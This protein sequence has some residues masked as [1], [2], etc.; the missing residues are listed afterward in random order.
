MSYWNYFPYVTVAE[1]KEKAARSLEKLKKKNQAIE[2]VV[3]SGRT[4]AATWWG[5]AWNENLER[6]A[7]FSNRIG[8]GRSYVRNGAVLDL[9]IHPG[10]VAA[11]V[12]GT[13]AKPY[14][15]SI[16]IHEISGTD[17]NRIK[18]ASEGQLDSLQ[19]LLSGKFPKALGEIFMEPGKGLFPEPREIKFSCSCPDWAS[20]C[21]HV[22]AA[23]YGIGARLD[24]EP[25]LFFTLRKVEMRDLVTEAVEGKSRE[26]LKKASRKS[27]RVLEDVSI[28]EMFGIDLDGDTTPD[29]SDIAPEKPLKIAEPA[30]RAKRVKN[31][32]PKP[33]VPAKRGRPPKSVEKAALGKV[34]TPITSTKPAK[35]KRQAKAPM[36][37]VLEAV[38]KGRKGIGVAQICR[39]TGLEEQKVRNLIY[40]LK[41]MNRIKSIAWGIYSKA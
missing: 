9:R 8:R 11:L 7:D 13:R 19:E 39:K 5:K 16:N 32:L 10:K 6:Y 4:I 28:S 15:V 38:M 35:Q 30:P 26:L 31:G 2:P 34:K 21:K 3:L 29:F 1:K 20:M 23:L 17:W 12:Q 37:M 25:A 27:Q 22:A 14:E 41:K 36:D 24:N 18:K 33:A 40:R